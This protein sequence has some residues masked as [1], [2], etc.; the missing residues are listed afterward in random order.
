MS[1]NF[2]FKR[3]EGKMMKNQN[4]ATVIINRYGDIAKVHVGF[5]SKE[6]FE[7]GIKEI[8]NKKRE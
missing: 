7:E 5:A 8:L 1:M 6:R 2:K 4:P 3:I